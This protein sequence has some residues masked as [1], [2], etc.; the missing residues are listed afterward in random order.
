MKILRENS[1]NGFETSQN[2]FPLYGYTHSTA[3]VTEYYIW[4]V[5]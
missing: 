5:H 3:E 4:E 1:M 2:N